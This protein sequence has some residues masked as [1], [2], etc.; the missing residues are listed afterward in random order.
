MSLFLIFYLKT[1]IWAGGITFSILFSHINFICGSSPLIKV[2]LKVFQIIMTFYSKWLSLPYFHSQNFLVGRLILFQ[3]FKLLHKLLTNFLDKFIIFKW[4]WLS[5]F[6]DKLCWR[7][8]KILFIVCRCTTCVAVHNV[9]VGMS[10][11]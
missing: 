10:F 4:C 1:S 6:Y 11:W 8:L 7:K 5:K 2:E 3:F 9:K